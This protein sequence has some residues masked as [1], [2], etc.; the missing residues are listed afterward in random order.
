MYCHI[1]RVSNAINDSCSASRI[2]VIHNLTNSCELI[3][4]ELRETMAP[5]PYQ[6]YEHTV[7]GCFHQEYHTLILKLNIAFFCVLG[8]TPNMFNCVQS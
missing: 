7:V 2:D 6:I 3:Y 1:I 4:V 8:L 5:R